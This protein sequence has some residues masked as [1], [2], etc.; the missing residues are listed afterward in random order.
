MSHVFYFFS[1]MDDSSFKNESVN[2]WE[3]RC[4]RSWRRKCQCKCQ[5]P[6]QNLDNWP[7]VYPS[8]NEVFGISVS[9]GNGWSSWTWI[10]LLMEEILHHLGCTKPCKLCELNISTGAGFL[11]STVVC[12]NWLVSNYPADQCMVY[13]PSF[14]TCRK[15]YSVPIVISSILP[16]VPGSWV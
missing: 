11:P 14:S 15:C 13:L 6:P 3:K 7:V 4:E 2:V 16:K 5:W 12:W 9:D 10:I 1:P 8:Q